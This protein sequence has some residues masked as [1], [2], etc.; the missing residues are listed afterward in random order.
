V[1]SGA[2]PPFFSSAANSASVAFHEKGALDASSA[3]ASGVASPAPT[4]SSGVASPA[5]AVVTATA[6]VASPAEAVP[7][8]DASFGAGRV[9][10]VPN[11]KPLA[12]ATTHSSAA[13]RSAARA[14]LQTK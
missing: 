6:G 11:P 13:Q 4:A 5:A 12:H 7:T 14:I 1:A 2:L 9:S 8:T 3:A 10:A